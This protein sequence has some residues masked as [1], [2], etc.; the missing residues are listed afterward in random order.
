MPI[1]TSHT[2]IATTSLRTLSAITVP[3]PIP[4]ATEILIHVLWTASTPLDLH[5]NDSGLLVKY[6]H[7]LGDGI[8]GT[9]VSIGEN[10]QRVEVGDTVFGFSWLKQEGKAHQEFAVVEEW[11]VGVIPEGFSMQ[12]A[13]T[14][15]NNFVT[16]FHTLTA[17]LGFETPW[18][19][20]ENFVPQ[21]E[22]D[23]ILVWG[24]ASSV[25]QYAIQILRYYGY[26]KIIAVASARHHEILR[27]YG[28]TYTLDYNDTDIEA[29][30]QTLGEVKFVMDCIGSATGSVLPISKVVKAGAKV[31]ILLPV[32][33]R[34]SGEDVQ[35]V[36]GMDVENVDGV[37]WEEGVEVRGVRTHFYHHNEF[38][39]EHL[40]PD[41]M[42]AMLKEGIVEPNK[43]KIIE[44][45]TLLERA[46]KA[47][48]ALRRKE[49]RGERLVWRVADE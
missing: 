35:P 27:S 13:V 46:E 1:P 28:A 6:P 22:Q 4:S 14:L 2:A 38:F 31:A 18:P 21:N 37:S 26:G 8:A 23:L 41:I 33:V 25:G 5:Q 7:I 30:I 32:I 29:Q 44:G 17:D 16:V 12:Q 24:G 34:D 49:A 39:K 42:P 40:Q 43:Q 9:V 47:M 11:M 48:G 3:T 20:P 36:Y 45:S 15:P 19:K 10:V